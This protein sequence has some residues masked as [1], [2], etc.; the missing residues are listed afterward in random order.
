MEESA[1]VIR[2]LNSRDFGLRRG[3]WVFVYLLSFI[4]PF[5]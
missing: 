2:L 5:E 1:T 3:D 4:E